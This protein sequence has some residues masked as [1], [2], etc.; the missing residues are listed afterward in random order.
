MAQQAIGIM[1]VSLMGTWSNGR[2]VHT[3]WHTRFTAVSNRPAACPE[4]A[5]DILSAWGTIIVPLIA[6]NYSVAQAH[7]VDYDSLSGATGDVNAT[8]AYVGGSVSSKTPPN[9]G[10]M[11]RK[12][13][14]ATTRDARPGRVFIPGISEANVD[15]DGLVLQS[16][17]DQIGVA[18]QQFLTAVNGSSG[19]NY[20]DQSLVVYHTPSIEKTITK[21]VKVP[22]P[23]GIGSGDDITS[24]VAEQLATG[25]DR[26]LKA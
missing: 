4:V 19:P 6:D 7:Y 18:F 22:N 21:T 8:P 20:V 15:E 10:I 25:I 23:N 11:V 26:R 3:T 24:F 14:G 16:I 17:L 13:I 9:V 5:A 2:P 1:K 12:A